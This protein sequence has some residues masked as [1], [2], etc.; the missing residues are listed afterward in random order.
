MLSLKINILKNSIKEIKNWYIPLLAYLGVEK[1]STVTFKDGT[2]CILRNKSDSIA[3]YENFFM[4]I[5]TSNESFKINE[6]DIVVD[7]GAHV[8]Y[9][10]ILAAKKAKNG[11]IFAIEPDTESIETLKKNT[12]MNH[13][14]NVT[15]INSAVSNKKG[16]LTFYKDKDNYIASSIFE[17]LDTKQEQ[18]QSMRIDDIIKENNIEKIDFLKMDCEGAEYEIILNLN[19]TAL[20]KIR[21]ISLEVHDYIK[22]FSKKQIIKFLESKNF[23]VDTTY[24]LDKSSK[25]SMI[26]AINLNKSN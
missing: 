22:G 26:Y 25:I 23:K 2:K 5:N 21:K 13:L 8:G 9:F 20:T 24:P 19:D 11:H 16:L 4:K 17:S 1:K 14:K 6:D 12:K 18:I 3:F 15:I 10:T 7:V